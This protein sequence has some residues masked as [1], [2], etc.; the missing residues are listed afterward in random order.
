MA[1]GAH[2]VAQ[3]STL[4]PS[5]ALDTIPISSGT[6]EIGRQLSTP[7]YG[8]ILAVVLSAEVIAYY[9]FSNSTAILMHGGLDVRLLLITLTEWIRYMILGGAATT[10]LLSRNEFAAL[11]IRVLVTPVPVSRRKRILAIQM[12]LAVA[13]VAWSGLSPD[14][15]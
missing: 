14:Y 10:I 9:R 1:K 13:L 5:I 8:A 7:A 6:R 15:F 12:M 3:G 4:E 11:A 2:S